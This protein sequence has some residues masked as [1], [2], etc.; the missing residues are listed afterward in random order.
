MRDPKRIIQLLADLAESLGIAEDL[1][2]EL[3][4]RFPRSDDAAQMFQSPRKSKP[5]TPLRKKS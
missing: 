2:E 5:T 4:R 1:R 3:M